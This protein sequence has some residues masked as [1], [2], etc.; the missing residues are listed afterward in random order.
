MI[1]S[2]RYPKFFLSII[3]IY[4]IL[5]LWATPDYATSHFGAEILNFRMLN[6]RISLNYLI[7]CDYYTIFLNLLCYRRC[8]VAYSMLFPYFMLI[9]NASWLIIGTYIDDCWI[10]LMTRYIGYIFAHFGVSDDVCTFISSF[11]SSW[12]YVYIIYTCRTDLINT[13]FTVYRIVMFWEVNFR[14]ES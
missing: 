3:S 6:F 8:G 14:S 1:F 9:S 13:D 2:L 11:I 10:F 4:I 5:R 7:Y 12:K